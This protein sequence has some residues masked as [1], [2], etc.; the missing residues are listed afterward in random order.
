MEKFIEEL[1]GIIRSD[2]SDLEIKKALD[3][4]HDSDIAVV[5]E[6][7][8]DFEKAKLMR[9]LG[10][11]DA[12]N[13]ISYAE[14]KDEFLDYVN[15]DQAADIIENMDADD[16]VDVLEEMDESDRQEILEL[17]DDKDVKEDIQLI[18]SFNKDEVGSLMTTNFVTI[19]K[20]D[21]VKEAMKK[22]ISQAED[23][24]NI[25]TIF[26]CDD[27]NHFVAALD[28]KDL[29]ISRANQNLE[30][31]WM[32][33]YPTLHGHDKID[34]VLNHVKD[35]AEDIIPILDENEKIIGVLTANDVI[36]LVTDEAN[37][38][39]HRLAGL[40]EEEEVN[41]SVFQSIKKRMPWLALLLLLGLIVSS[42]VSAF[43]TVI[44]SV[45]AAVIFQSVVFD[46]AG[47]GGT[48]SLAV[49][50]TTI[51]NDDSLS[52]K[53]IIKMI[54]KEIRVGLINGLILGVL[55][56]GVILGF[57]VVR[58][59]GVFS[60]NPETF[61]FLDCVKIASCVGIALCIAISVSSLFG[62]ILP[63]FFKKIKIDPAVASGPMITTINDICSA[64]IY[65]TLV[66][67]FFSML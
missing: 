5:L 32:C 42:V 53:K 35:Y 33:N 11:E 24:D 26:V 6:Y 55:S 64:C 19:N 2:K 12:S 8:E 56:F 43:E 23:N 15:M 17:I 18:L 49:T 65:Y 21:N 44:A 3:D 63:V 10:L 45:S 38:D 50:L 9:I 28:L 66:G 37:E 4:Y 48:Q 58:H 40:T 1:L 39:Y 13:V 16:A 34:D 14:D 54:F 57:L 52:K 51:N 31:K 25:S 67:L 27:D 22:V 61:V 36:E 59:Q 60:S 47:N 46:M 20:G 30:D 41:E 7:L 29:I 62:L